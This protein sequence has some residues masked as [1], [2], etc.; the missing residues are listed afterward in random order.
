M[1][2]S[3]TDVVDLL[4]DQHRQIR[5]AF[6]KA[7]MPGPARP[8]ALR[9]LVRLLAVHES[10]EEA[11]VHPLVRHA[12][13]CGRQLAADRRREEK[14]AK[15]LLTA[16]WKAGP[17]LVGYLGY[18]RY[19][20][21]LLTLRRAVLAH[22]AREE[23]EEFA[24]LREAV[25]TPRRR[26]LGWEVRATQAMAPTRPHRMVNNEMTN[27]LATPLFG[28][29]DR[30]LDRM[31]AMRH[32]HADGH[33]DGRLTG[34]GSAMAGLVSSAMAGAAASGMVRGTGQSLSD[35]INRVRGR[36]QALSHMHAVFRH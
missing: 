34:A 21:A 11:H 13:P 30:A 24:A 14:Q 17:R 26:L 25:S 7:A 27:K 28:P 9:D 3:T 5:R 20:S 29:L 19:L 31:S 4:T 6:R 22:A 23:R 10:A 36:G 1:G 12:T 18:A 8:R 32:D 35:S 2:R 15:E 33:L 16:L